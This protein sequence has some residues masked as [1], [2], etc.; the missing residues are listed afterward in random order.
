MYQQKPILSETRLKRAKVVLDYEQQV[1]KKLTKAIILQIH[2][3]IL[4]HNF[5]E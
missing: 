2:T 1:L 5:L 4:L 3:T